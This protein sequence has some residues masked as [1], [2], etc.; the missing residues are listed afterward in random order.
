[1][2][3]K[4]GY[5]LVDKKAIDEDAL[6]TIALDAGAEDIRND[7]KE[8]NYEVI[9]SPDNI[10]VVNDAIK[11]AGIPVSLSEVT[12]LPKSYVTIDGKTAEQM[13]R[14]MDV[15]EDSEDVQNVYAN[16]DIPDEVVA[17]TGK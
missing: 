9:C 7:P 1:M 3:E 4:K 13:V 11:R 14:L 12:M 2:F 6:I 8:E 5:I 15:L 10:G 17:K 16:F